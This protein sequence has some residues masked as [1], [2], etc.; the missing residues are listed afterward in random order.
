MSF[1]ISSKFLLNELT[2]VASTTDDGSAFQASMTLWEK[3]CFLV[4]NLLYCLNNLRSCPRNSWPLD[5]NSKNWWWSIFSFLRTILQ[6]SI[7]SPR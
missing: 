5:T 7:K 3:K 6:V 4:F 2:D 1:Q